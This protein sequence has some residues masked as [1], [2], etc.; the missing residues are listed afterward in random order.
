MK[1]IIL[2]FPVL[3]VAVG[4]LAAAP[5]AMCGNKEKVEKRVPEMDL[6][7]RDVVYRIPGIPANGRIHVKAKITYPGEKKQIT[8][9][10]KEISS[11]QAGSGIETRSTTIKER[12]EIFSTRTSKPLEIKEE[13]IHFNNYHQKVSTDRW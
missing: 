12:E 9:L 3:I 13:E 5:V 10:E 1:N 8:I 7:I 11:I 4:I 2:T 6:L